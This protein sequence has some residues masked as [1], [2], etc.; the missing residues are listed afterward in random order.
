MAGSA[1]DGATLR[2]DRLVRRAWHRLIFLSVVAAQFCLS[3]CAHYVYLTADDFHRGR[4]SDI[5]FQRDNA[6]CQ[7]AATV[8]QNEVGGGDPHGVYNWAYIACM[9]RR[10]Y[11]TDNID[12]LDI[13]A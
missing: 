13:G 12:L 6:T 7:T 9:A 11:A 10:G 8:R 1:V 4:A 3:G 5:Q 2:Q